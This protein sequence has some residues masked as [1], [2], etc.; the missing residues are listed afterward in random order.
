MTG[1]AEVRALTVRP[2]WSHYLRSGAKQVENR[3]WPT[4]WRG[5]LVIHAGKTL[6]RRGFAVGAALGHPV[7][8]DDVNVGEFIAV[9]ELVD[10]HAAGRACGPAC[11]QWGEPSCWHWQLAAVRSLVT[12]EG[13]GARGLF[14]PPAEVLAQIAGAES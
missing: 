9:G 1:H 6:D 14:V 3:T 2:P 7:D 12:V 13:R 5:P 11:Q 8:P 10:V 4:R